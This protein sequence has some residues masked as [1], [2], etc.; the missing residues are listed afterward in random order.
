[1]PVL[2]RRH[3]IIGVRLSEEEY[4]ALE[5]YCVESRARSISDLARS[6]IASLVSRAGRESALASAVDQNATQVKDLEDKIARLSSEVALLRAV[7][8]TGSGRIEGDS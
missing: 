5:K 3:R 4:A 2:F 6:A 8:T 1:M 7:S